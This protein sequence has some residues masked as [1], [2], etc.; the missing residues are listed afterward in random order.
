MIIQKSKTHSLRIDPDN[1][2]HHLFCNNGTW[3][4]HYTRHLPDYTVERV[5]QSLMTRDRA[6]ARH[7]RDLWL[8]GLQGERGAA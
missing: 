5:R 1:P 7:R 2:D 4:I 3:W 6:V 8:A